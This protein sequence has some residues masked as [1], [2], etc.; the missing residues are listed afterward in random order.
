MLLH[1]SCDINQIFDQSHLSLIMYHDL[2]TSKDHN[3][4]TLNEAE[5]Y[6]LEFQDSRMFQKYLQQYFGMVK[7]ID[8]NVGKLMSYL[9]ESG[10][11]EED[12]IIV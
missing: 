4:V 8:D 12:T 5:E 11:E 9:K 3:N 6:L 10:I 2:P 1:V 7:C